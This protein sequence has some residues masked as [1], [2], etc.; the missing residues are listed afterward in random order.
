MFE[1]LPK[2]E[3]D[4]SEEQLREQVFAEFCHTTAACYQNF[5]TRAEKTGGHIRISVHPFF[6]ERFPTTTKSLLPQETVPDALEHMR[7]G[8][9]RTVTSVTARP[10]SSPLIIFEEGRGIPQTS[11][12]LRTSVTEKQNTSIEDVL[13]IETETG[14][15]SLAD[16]AIAKNFDTLY[17]D[18]HPTYSNTLQLYTELQYQKRQELREYLAQIT[19]VDW[20]VPETPEEINAYRQRLLDSEE[21]HKPLE[22]AR[23][24]LV[25]YRQRFIADFVTH[26]GIKSILAQGS[27]ITGNEKRVDMCLGMI[28]QMS[29]DMGI[30][31]DIS[32]YVLPDREQLK[33]NGVTTKETNLRFPT[34]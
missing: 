31:V 34:E 14:S 22:A 26:T 12:L 8:F 33:N 16:A 7:E 21:K 5:K 13:V 20:S 29:R 10:N 11:E 15:G 2:Y 9:N 24:L 1:G 28:V 4:I 23:K 18:T 32:K 19:T 6:A 3:T 27:Y 25:S 17:P 30:P